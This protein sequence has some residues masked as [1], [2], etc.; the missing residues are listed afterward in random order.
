MPNM[1]IIWL[2]LSLTLQNFL[3]IGFGGAGCGFDS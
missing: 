2:K 1:S 3:T